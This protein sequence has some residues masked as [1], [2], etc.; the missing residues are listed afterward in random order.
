M[1]YSSSSPSAGRKREKGEK[2]GEGRESEVE[3]EVENKAAEKLW[4]EWR[5]GPSV[6]SVQKMV[7]REGSY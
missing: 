1:G 3:G 5:R 6:F 4:G 7:Y 2:G